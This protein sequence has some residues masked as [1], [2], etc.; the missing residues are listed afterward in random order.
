MLVANHY[1]ETAQGSEPP[2]RQH[3]TYS[4]YGLRCPHKHLVS[5]LGFNGELADSI[6]GYYLLGNG[7]RAFNSKL[8][9]FNSPDSWS[10]FGES[11][12]N[13]YVYCGG[14][15][16]NNS[17]PTGH[18][19]F[20]TKILNAIRGQKKRRVVSSANPAYGIMAPRSAPQSPQ[21]DRATPTS[22]I[23]DPENL[24]MS[25]QSNL[26][27]PSNSVRVRNRTE[28]P[29]YAS[30]NF[31]V[32]QPNS[33]VRLIRAIQFPHYKIVTS[34]DRLGII[35]TRHQDNVSNVELQGRIRG[36]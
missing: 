31:E 34:M 26:H 22:D 9:R 23:S 28:E 1:Q 35:T 10:P 30:L 19:G 13:A 32:Q 36:G 2:H 20:W 21:S 29:I 14:D 12:P 15:P 8:M 27:H 6:A 7:Y 3:F 5:L 11:G 16:V 24:Y 25:I 4:A 17:D 33:N 18:I